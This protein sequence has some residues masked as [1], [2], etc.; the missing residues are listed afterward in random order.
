MEAPVCSDSGLIL[1]IVESVLFFSVIVFLM[2][3]EPPDVSCDKRN[4]L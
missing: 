1:S 2:G 4:K 3:F